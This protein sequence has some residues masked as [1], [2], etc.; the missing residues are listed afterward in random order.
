M[1]LKYIMGRLVFVK[2]LFEKGK[3]QFFMEK[4]SRM[5]QKVNQIFKVYNYGK[6]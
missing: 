2:V 4:K 1:L 5:K 6:K 3:I